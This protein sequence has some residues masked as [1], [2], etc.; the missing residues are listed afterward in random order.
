MLS[1]VYSCAPEQ[2]AMYTSFV[3]TFVAQTVVLDFLLQEG[4]VRFHDNRILQKKKVFTT[5]SRKK[6]A[7]RD[8]L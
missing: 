2:D 7:R 3:S 6:I 5:P 8:W 4:V 1:C